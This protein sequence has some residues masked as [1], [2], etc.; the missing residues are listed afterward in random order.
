MTVGLEVSSW[1]ERLA[2]GQGGPAQAADTLVSGTRWQ[3]RCGCEWGTVALGCGHEVWVTLH[4]PLLVAAWPLATSGLL[5]T[6]TRRGPRDTELCPG[7]GL[8]GDQL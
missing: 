5:S 8:R 3:T 1:H 6:V 2:R 7:A 4:T